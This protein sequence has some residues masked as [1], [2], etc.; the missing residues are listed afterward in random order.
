MRSPRDTRVGSLGAP[1]PRGPRPLPASRRASLDAVALRHAGDEPGRSAAWKPAADMPVTAGPFERDLRPVGRR[2]R[3][4]VRQRPHLRPR[5]RRHVAPH[6]HHPRRAD[7]PARRD[8]PRPR[9]RARRCTARGPS[10]RSRCPPTPRRGRDPPL[11][12]ARHRA[13]TTAT[14]CSSAP[15]GPSPDRVP[16]PPRHVR[17]LLRPGRATRPTRSSST[18]TRPA[19]RWC[20]ASAT[21]G[22][23]TT[24]RPA[25]RPAATT[26]SSPTESDDLVHWAG[27]TRRLHRRARRH[28]RRADRV[29]VRRR[30][31]RPLVPVHRARAGSARRMAASSGARTRTGARLPTTLVLESDDPFHFDA[32]DEV[33]RIDAHAAEVV[34]DERRRDVGQPLRLGPGRR[35]PG[36]APLGD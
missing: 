27:P 6:R 16:D 5:P 11:G 36:A 35:V 13:T 18:A 33:G 22:S 20:C 14:G 4:L 8:A 19:T 32:A 34:V 9:H 17:R 30:A 7:A 29:A 31:R 24:R 10:S 26:S 2:G 1:H 12:A 28:L 23:C 15:A 25:S 3:A 21:G